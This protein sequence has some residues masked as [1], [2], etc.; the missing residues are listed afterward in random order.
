MLHRYADSLE[1]KARKQAK[2]VSVQ[3]QHQQQAMVL[4]PMRYPASSP[5]YYAATAAADSS[6][7]LLGG[8]SFM[9][10]SLMT[11]AG[12]GPCFAITAAGLVKMVQDRY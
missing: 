8:S 3:Q 5:A 10:P 7:G 6:S 4:Q 11:P 12:A 1:I 2:Q 9:A